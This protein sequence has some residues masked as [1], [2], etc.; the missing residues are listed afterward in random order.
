[1]TEKRKSTQKVILKQRQ[2]A[3]QTKCMRTIIK[4]KQRLNNKLYNQTNY[5]ANRS[6]NKASVK[7]AQLT[8]ETLARA[9]ASVGQ[10]ASFARAVEMR[11]V[12]VSAAI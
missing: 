9:Q 6:V 10:L 3:L 5:N 8:T 1:M 7:L 12:K 4:I 2:P 11:R